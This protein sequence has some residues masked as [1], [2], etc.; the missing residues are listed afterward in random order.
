M[1]FRDLLLPSL[2]QNLEFLQTNG[3]KI[4]MGEWLLSNE[5]IQPSLLIFTTKESI[6][7]LFGILFIQLPTNNW[8]P[9]DLIEQEASY[10]YFCKARI[11]IKSI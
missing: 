8:I 6:G 7:I 10:P 5:Q 3:Y 9:Y 11:Y 1:K 4:A 2:L